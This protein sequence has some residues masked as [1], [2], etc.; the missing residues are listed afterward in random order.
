MIDTE[1]ENKVNLKRGK[2]R[3]EE[4]RK[5]G[6]ENGRGSISSRGYVEAGAGSDGQA[7][8][9]DEGSFSRDQDGERGV[10]EGPRFSEGSGQGIRQIEPEGIDP[11]PGP[12]EDSRRYE[13]GL[14]PL[15]PEPKE[16]PEEKR[17]REAELHRQRQQRYADKKKAEQGALITSPLIDSERE[18]SASR[19]YVSSESLT[20]TIKGADADGKRPAVSFGLRLPGMSKKNDPEKSRLFSNKEADAELEKMTYIYQQGA[21]LIDDLLEVIVKDHEPVQ[22]WALSDEEADMLAEMHLEKAKTDPGAARS[23]RVLLALYDRIY[24]WMIA[25]PRLKASGSHI[26]KHGGLSF[27]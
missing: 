10:E 14:A 23:A 6:E 22:I 5:E 19:Q 26:K 2:N 16:S 20:R 18:T 8:R 25:L 24:R 11:A 21:S 9:G 17:E 27:K 1:K 12:R 4:I 7:T 3:L 13:A 15:I